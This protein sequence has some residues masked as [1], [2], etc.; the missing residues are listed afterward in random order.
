MSFVFLPKQ[1]MGVNDMFVALCK[2]ERVSTEKFLSNFL[3][4]R[5]EGERN[6]C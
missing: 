6:A 4:P 3:T 5:I 2:N 1:E